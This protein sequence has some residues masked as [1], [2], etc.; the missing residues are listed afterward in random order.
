MI[1]VLVVDDEIPSQKELSYIINQHPDF[2]V[3]GTAGSGK[4][5]LELIGQLKPQV[6][7]LDIQLYDINGLDLAEK[8]S[9]IDK[10]IVVI[11]ATAHDDFAIKAYELNA[12]DYVV[13]PFD[14]VRIFKTLDR[15]RN[16][17]A[18]HNA[19][20]LIEQTSY[21]L[22][23]P[24][25]RICAVGNGRY[26]VINCKD[27]VYVTAEERKTLLKLKDDFLPSS[28]TLQELSEKLD[29]RDF[30]RVHRA[31]VVNMRYIKEVI[32]WFN[33]SFKLIMEDRQG[34]EI[35]VS[36]HYARDLKQ[37]LGL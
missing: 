1:K 21:P 12:L 14:E 24:L 2:Q 23:P 27:I 30:L 10:K 20:M 9:H 6:A 37:R 11:F 3:I 36:R 19:S 18:L 22:E 5:A 16:N 26:M 29:Q 13:K 31:Y 35:P 17:L 34:S 25:E 33:G 15:I 32:P 4:E 8:V 7:F 28:F